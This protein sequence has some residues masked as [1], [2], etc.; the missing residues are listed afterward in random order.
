M[1]RIQ[2]RWFIC[3]VCKNKMAACKN[4]K[5]STPRGHRKKMWCWKCQKVMNMIQIN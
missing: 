3:P 2:M 4:S 1:P 5:H